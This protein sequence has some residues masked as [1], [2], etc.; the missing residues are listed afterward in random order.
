MAKT[1]L[2][3]PWDI[4]Y[5][6]L[7]ALFGEDPEIEIVYDEENNEIKMQVEDAAK[8]DALTR[9][10]PAEKEFGNV[11]LKITVIPANGDNV[12]ALFEKA[13]CGNPA[14]V[15]A[16]KG[17]G[18]FDRNYVV[19]AHDVVQYYADNLADINRNR[20]TLYERIARRVFGDL[21]EYGGVSFCTATKDNLIIEL[22]DPFAEV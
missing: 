12:A 3:A 22:P 2:S 16:Q 7:S 18:V 15:Y 8:A 20:S 5:K 17:T 4:F 6:E 11:K 19:F 21:Q 1:N 13:F 9:L 10:L 14:F